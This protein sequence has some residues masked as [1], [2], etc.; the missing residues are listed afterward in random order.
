MNHLRI[1]L[2]TASVAASM[3]G[4]DEGPVG[5]LRV[6][7]S[8]INDAREGI[9]PSATAGGW[10]VEFDHAVL[11]LTDFRMRTAAGEEALVVVPPTVSELV[12]APVLAYELTDVGAQRWDRTSYHVG[13]VTDASEVI[14]V[15]D[16]IARRMRDEGWSSYYS[17]RFVA[18]AGTEDEDGNPVTEIPFE[19]GFPVEVDY[20]QCQNGIDRTDGV[21]V[22]AS[23][24]VDVEITWHITHLFFDSFVEDASLRVEPHASNWQGGESVLTLEDLNV[25]LGG[26]RAM[27]GGPLRDSDGNFVEYIPGMSGADTLAEFVLAGRPG[28]FNGLEGFCMTSLRVL[29]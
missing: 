26:L 5:D 27:D 22:P 20:E 18:P 29:D 23:S 4:C 24:A 2:I 9:A 3:L 13:P 17:G 1:L 8:G 12:P 21:V 16:Q 7:V 11:S 10:A 6:R 15:D 25:P 28:H 14:G 19:Y